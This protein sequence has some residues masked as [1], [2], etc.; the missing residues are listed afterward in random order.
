MTE[1]S[2]EILWGKG[3]VRGRGM[4]GEGVGGG[5]GGGSWEGMLG[6]VWWGRG[7]WGRGWWGRGL[8]GGGGNKKENLMFPYLKEFAGLY[9][10]CGNLPS[11]LFLY[12]RTGTEKYFARSGTNQRK[13]GL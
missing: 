10:V 1:D 11:V 2:Q 8:W 4:V 5:E 6:G 3:A 13:Y 7:W 12:L 9:G